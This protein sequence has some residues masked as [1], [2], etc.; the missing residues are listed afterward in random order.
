MRSRK[1]DLSQPAIVDAL[2]GVGA[3]VLRLCAYGVSCD[4]LVQHG[5]RLYLIEVKNP[6]PVSKRKVKLTD[7][8]WLRNQI[9][10]SELELMRRFPVAVVTTPQE[11]LRVI[12][13]GA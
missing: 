3:E 9:T 6:R 7:A 11:A 13:V 8:E 1:R 10:D 2:E 12:G 5:N 4:L